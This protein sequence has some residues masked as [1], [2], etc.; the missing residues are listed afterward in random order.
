[1]SGLDDGRTVDLGR[2][3][4]L[5]GIVGAP[6]LT[7]IAKAGALTL[8]DIRIRD[9]FILADRRSGTYYCYVQI[10]NRLGDSAALRGVEAYTS[11]DCLH[12]S[13]P[14]TVFEV[15]ADSWA[16]QRVWAPEVHEYRG[17]YY[18]L[19]TLTAEGTIGQIEGLPPMQKRGTQILVGDSP[20]G[21]FRA[22]RNGP[23]TPC[24][25]LA[26]DG[27]LWVEDGTPYMVFCHEW[28]QR[29]NGSM[30]A[31]ALSPDLS[32]AAGPPET[33][34]HA[35]DA[36][37]VR[38]FLHGQGRYRGFVTDGPFLYRTSAGTLLM[39]WSSFGTDGYAV[40]LALSE[41][42]SVHGPWKQEPEPL[43]RADGGHCMLFR[44]FEGQLTL[45][46]HQPNLGP[47]ERG[48]LFPLEDTGHRVRLSKA[49]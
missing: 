2:R 42:G 49:A 3:S 7:R 24:E 46:L 13:G 9:P 11:K 43:F 27:T 47:K 10:G 14:V 20:L 5:R 44:T 15:P 19:V 29:R 34:F 22:F 1:M 30:E 4:L 38:A 26:L 28:V 33:L 37:W 23:H 12:W 36:P 17:K 48:R 8:N 6:A 32:S 41:S 25:W 18:L 35:A 40:G 16:R 31:M 39:T 21:P 45:M